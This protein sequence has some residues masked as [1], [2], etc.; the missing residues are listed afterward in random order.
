MERATSKQNHTSAGTPAK[1]RWLRRLA[2]IA[3]AL[4]VLAV[5]AAGALLVRLSRGPISLDFL[6]SYLITAFEPADGSFRVT[7]GATEL[8]WTERWYDVDLN[9]RDVI[10][11][12]ASGTTIASLSALAMELSVRALLR[13]VVAPSEIELAAPL[14]AL[15]REPDGNIDFGVGGDATSAG[16]ES[17]FAKLF[18][19]AGA[20][21]SAAPAARFLR[22]IVVRDGQLALLDRETGFRT[23]ADAVTLDITRAGEQ[24]DVHVTTAL[25]LGE[26]RIPIQATIA[27]GAASGTQVRLTFSDLEPAAALAAANVLNPPPGS[28]A[29]SVLDAAAYL[30]LPLAGT[31]DIDLD[32]ADAIRSVKLD[33]SA[34]SGM[35]ALPPPLDRQLPI[36]RIDLE[37]SYD[38]AAD[39]ADLQHLEVDLG[40]PE[41]RVTGRWSGRDAGA[42][43][44]DAQVINLPASDLA[45]YWPPAAAVEARTWVTTNIT[46]GSVHDAAVTLRAALAPADPPAFTL[47]ELTG[48]LAFTGLSVRYVDTMPVA[49]GVGGTATFSTKGFDFRVTSGRI[50]GVAV[51]S[52]KVV[53]AGLPDKVT[54]IAIDAQA[55]GTIRDALAIVDA[56]PLH[57]AR[58]IGIDPRSVSGDMT[59]R[60]KLA[61]PLDGAP[62]PNDLGVGVA[63]QLRGAALPKAVGDWD[64]SAGN[65]ALTVGSD[66]LSITGDARIAGVGCDVRLHEDL[67]ATSGVS[68]RI[69]VQ[70]RVDTDGRAALGFDLRPWVSGPTPV[71]AHIEQQPGGKGT[72]A[73]GIDLTDAVLA[74][75]KLRLVK[76]PSAPG[77]A[78]LTLTLDGDSV[79]AVSPFS[80]S[81]PGASAQGKATLDTG[82]ARIATLT[83]DGILPPAGDGDASPQFLLDLRPAT[84]GHRF[85]LTSNDASTLLRLLMPDSRTQGGRLSFAGNIDLA[86]KGLP[87][88]GDLAATD[89]KLTSSPLFARLLMLSSM[90]GILSTFQG[91]GLSFDTMTVGIGYTA[92]SVTF[93]DGALDGPSVRLVF[94]GMVDSGKNATSIDGTLIPSFYGLNTVVARVPLIG[95]LFGGSD[96]VIAIDFTMRGPVADP[97]IAVRPLS[98]IAPGVLRSLARRVPW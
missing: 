26:E 22:S 54:T 75:P 92:D 89:F 44:V 59:G 60:V 64:L 41:V 70:S 36:E 45:R 95:G 72:V 55:R 6:T 28:V 35:I 4:V 65:L 43:T 49:A 42:L 91:E 7:I 87:F 56:E 94:N 40:L 11:K 76:Q 17:V 79:T 12:D 29:A 67:A 39:T 16:G 9:V 86:A 83:L 2:R 13:G 8:I 62:I 96:G 24:L 34:A 33:G 5:L 98:S 18:A 63:A 71:T 78:D 97:Q 69:D 20:D 90:S 14:L 81:S 52:A 47:H 3:G 84:T 85:D 48:R 10:C 31:V 19:G 46:A 88:S 38:A 77:R 37:V 1:N 80:F 27:R 15:V 58:K 25:A 30:R 73:L 23:Q 68:R 50:A 32:P 57:Y 93:K 21:G 82:S 74:V 53:I 66:A 61:F 51:P